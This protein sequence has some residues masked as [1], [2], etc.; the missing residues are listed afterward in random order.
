MKG[1]FLAGRRGRI[2]TFVLNGWAASE[3]AWDLC[4]FPRD[5]IFS[6]IEQLDGEPEKAMREAFAKLRDQLR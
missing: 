2:K 6:Y 5:R 3:Q 1:V 4:R